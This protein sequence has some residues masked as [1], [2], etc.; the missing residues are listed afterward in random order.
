[1]LCRK[2]PRVVIPS[3]SP[4]SPFHYWSA[5]EVILTS[6]ASLDSLSNQHYTAE[7]HSLTLIS[8]LLNEGQTLRL[9][10]GKDFPGQKS[11]ERN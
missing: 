5:C 7:S 4:F 8:F 1:M 2:G 10:V 6:N 11:A 9:E 3:S